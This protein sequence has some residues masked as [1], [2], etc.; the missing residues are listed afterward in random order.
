M[1]DRLGSGGLI[2]KTTA[3]FNSPEWGN[4]RE[5]L[6]DFS[7]DWS[8][9]FSTSADV[10]LLESKNVTGAGPFCALIELMDRAITSL[11]RGS[12]LATK[13]SGANEQGASIQLEESHIFEADDAELITETLRMKLSRYALAWKFGPDAP[14]YAYIQVKTTP[15]QD[16]ANDVAVDAFLAPF[17]LLEKKTTLAR[18]GR[19][20]PDQD[21]EIL[22]PVSTPPAGAPSVDPAKKE[23]EQTQ[24]TNAGAPQ[25]T[26]KF[27]D[28]AVQ[29]FTDSLHED[30]SHA[31]QKLIAALQIT[32][33]TLR[34]KKLKELLA[35]WPGITADTIITSKSAD[36]LANAIATAY[37]HGVQSP[38]P[39][40]MTNAFN[41]D[42]PRD[43]QGRFSDE[44]GK[45]S[46]AEADQRLS[47]G[48]EVENKAGRKIKFG[49]RL[50]GY[51]DKHP[52]GADRKAYLNHAVETVRSG[53]AIPMDD[54]EVYTKVFK[55]HDGKEKGMVTLSA[56]PQGE[57]FNMYRKDAYKIPEVERSAREGKL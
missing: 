1:L 36:T 13:T 18:Y 35:A 41:P 32:D 38:G 3:A 12:S 50:K 25:V 40:Q 10:S 6:K 56:S 37:A 31:A 24:F 47:K 28:A 57:V 26:D 2:G 52:Q 27:T 48:F 16:V 54:R 33:D 51:L 15:R 4:F 53:N 17:G 7:E 22:Q 39:A 5:A 55:G 34:E 8:G 29:Q 30:L 44:P 42:Q 45:I 23:E 11:L 43:E 46:P 19:P 49:P 21:A 20:L 14:Q 9:V